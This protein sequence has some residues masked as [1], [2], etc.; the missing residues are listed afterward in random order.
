MNVLRKSEGWS[1]SASEKIA[2]LCAVSTVENKIPRQGIK[3]FEFLIRFKGKV[4][5]MDIRN[6][7]GAKK[8]KDEAINDS[9]SVSQVKDLKSAPSAPKTASPK[10]AT[11]TKP[12]NTTPS[13]ATAKSQES[14][15]KRSLIDSD[16]EDSNEKK[17]AVENS[18]KRSNLFGAPKSAVAEAS[19]ETSNSCSSS[20]ASVPK[21]VAESISWPAGAHVPYSALVATF[22]AISRVSGRLDKENLF[23][24][25]FRAAIHSTPEG[26][27]A[28]SC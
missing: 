21:D 16:D 9:S 12:I 7:F 15:K 3:L 17:S 18:P 4:E 11:P 26:W 10:K 6:F 8:A 27:F 19:S 2:A 22:D 23:T 13:K 5:G 24:K 25:L 28:L 20:C 14:N 1:A